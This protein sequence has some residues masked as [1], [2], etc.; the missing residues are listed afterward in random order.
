MIYRNENEM[1]KSKLKQSEHLVTRQL[2]NYTWSQ[3]CDNNPDFNF[4]LSCHLCNVAS[5]LKGFHPVS[6]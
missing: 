6:E 3:Q 5:S 2:L 4:E 1:N